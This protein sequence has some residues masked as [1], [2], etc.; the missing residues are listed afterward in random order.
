MFPLGVL[1][2]ILGYAATY[3][4]AANLGNGGGGPTLAESLGFKTVIAPPGADK[5]NLTG[6]P[7]A[8]PNVGSMS[9]SR[10]L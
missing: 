8:T 3:T 5:P 10:P 4:G 7:A 2:L 9:G 1:C 6:Q